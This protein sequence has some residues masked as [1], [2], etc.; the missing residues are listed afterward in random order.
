MFDLP[1]RRLRAT[2]NSWPSSATAADDSNNIISVSSRP[3]A[4]A[5]YRRWSVATWATLK[6]I[7]PEITLQPRR[8]LCECWGCC[9]ARTRTVGSRKG[10]RVLYESTK[11]GLLRHR[12][13]WWCCYSRALSKHSYIP[14]PSV[15]PN[16]RLVVLAM[17]CWHL[18]A[19]SSQPVSQAKAK[20]KA[21][22]SPLSK[23]H[24]NNHN[25]KSSSSSRSRNG[26]NSSH[27]IVLPK[28]AAAAG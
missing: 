7:K 16:S 10:T 21:P 23:Y 26:S 27:V 28:A 14:S 15:V 11:C 8:L 25:S 12:D 18:R 6:N 17:I 13:W 3:A 5:T 20:A 24:N 19:A 1:N 4:A 2:T 22:A 9:P